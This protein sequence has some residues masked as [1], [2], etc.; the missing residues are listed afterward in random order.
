MSVLTI[1]DHEFNELVLYMRENFGI[2]LGGK[3]KLIEGRMSTH[4][5][6]SGHESFG[7]YLDQVF[8]D[9]S[10]QELANLINRLTTNHTY[11]FREEAHFHF[12]R[13]TVLPE[14]E[15]TV[16]DRD[17]RIWSAGCSSGEE[18]YS[19]AMTLQDYYGVSRA[20]WDAS[21]LATDISAKVL[22]I[23]RH[24]RY[25]SGS[26]DNLP[27]GWASRFFRAVNADTVEVVDPLRR[28]VMFR[29][30]NLIQDTFPLRR[31]FH[32]I[33]CRNVMIYFDRQTKNELIRRFF[34]QTEPGGYLFIGHAETIDK[35]E[36]GYSYVRP[37]VFR[38]PL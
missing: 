31:R 4:V 2:N 15:R 8:Q 1:S 35:D 11:F 24:G 32:V 36:T 6:E 9:T 14:L 3:R 12:L 27:A 23:A 29:S 38:K 18:P 16:R 10:G 13:Q 20:L 26:L 21:V 30:L 25:P 33:F 22:Q 5:T 17:I 7:D 34:Q 28:D 37:A 19:I